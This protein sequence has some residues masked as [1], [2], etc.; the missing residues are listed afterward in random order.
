[1]SL[2]STGGE[3]FTPTWCKSSY[4]SNDGPDCVEVAAAP[5]AVQVRDSKNVPGPQIGFTSDAWADF[6]TYT[7]G[8]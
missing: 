6:V 2:K 4:S 5:G 7:A 3:D 1:M 8:G